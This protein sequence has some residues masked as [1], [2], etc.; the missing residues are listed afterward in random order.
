MATLFDFGLLESSTSLFAFILVL[1]VS[2]AV[3]TAFPFLK[4]SK[5][6]ATILSICFGMITLFNPAILNA[7]KVMVPW[8]GMMVAFI[9]FILTALFTLGYTQ[10]DLAKTIQSRDY[11]MQI[12][13]WIIVIS[14]I[15]FIAALSSQFAVFTGEDAAS[16]TASQSNQATVTSAS[17]DRIDTTAI[18]EKGEDALVATLFHPKMLS[19]IA[20]MLIAVFAAIFLAQSNKV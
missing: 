18:E 4:F 11:G 7:I 16:D 10:K 9:I 3:L 17:G 5:F 19:M 12:K 8:F 13:V 20:I 1:V 14:A 15:I 2:Y 6:N